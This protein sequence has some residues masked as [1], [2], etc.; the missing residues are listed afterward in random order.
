M[1]QHEFQ[2]QA[3]AKDRYMRGL[4]EEELDLRFADIVTNITILTPEGQIG[5]PGHGGLRWWEIFTHVLEELAMR[6]RGM[7]HAATLGDRLGG[8]SPGVVKLG[9]KLRADYPDGVPKSFKLF[10]YGKREHLEELFENGAL[11][12][13]PASKYK[14]STL[15]VAIADDELHF[16]TIDGHRRTRYALD[17]NFYCFCSAWIHSDRLVNDFSATAVLVVHDPETFFTRLAEALK[18]RNYDIHINRVTYVDPL[19]VGKESL[20]G[21]PFV[22]HMRFAYQC[23]HRLIAAPPRP[24]FDLDEVILRMTPVKD[25]ATLYVE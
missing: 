20:D 19:L 18:R 21:F 25:I 8:P 9:A 2:R 22:K 10:K 6:G 15:N 24:T 3:Y 5:V 16:E 23:E 7:P 4:S 14:D 12:L 13:K 17:R 11:L 1:K